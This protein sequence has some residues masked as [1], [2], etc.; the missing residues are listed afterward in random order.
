VRHILALLIRKQYFGRVLYAF[1]ISICFGSHDPVDLRMYKYQV[2]FQMEK[3]RNMKKTD[4][5][6]MSPTA[7]LGVHM[8]A[9]LDWFG[10]FGEDLIGH[11]GNV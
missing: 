9:L 6:F 3:G 1:R 11:R 5:S 7:N 8:I 10:L 4:I 2:V